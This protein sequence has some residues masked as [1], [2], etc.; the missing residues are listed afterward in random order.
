MQ[1][2]KKAQK[3]TILSV[4]VLGIL[5]VSVNPAIAMIPACGINA[6]LG[7]IFGVVARRKVQ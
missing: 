6:C 3:A 2:M 4:L 1:N 7:V 5:Y